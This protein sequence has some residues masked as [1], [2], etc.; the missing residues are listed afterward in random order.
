MTLTSERVNRDVID[1]GVERSFLGM[2]EDNKYIDHPAESANVN[3]G[4]NRFHW[5]L[6]AADTPYQPRGNRA[7]VLSHM[8][9]EIIRPKF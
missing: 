9:H 7:A 1:G 3:N 8:K 5:V 2:R 6:P 4:D